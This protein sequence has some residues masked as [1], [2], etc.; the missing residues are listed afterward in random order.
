[1]FLKLG[2][3]KL[4]TVLLAFIV[5]SCG[6]SK[7]QMTVDTAGNAA[8]VKKDEV[9]IGQKYYIVSVANTVNLRSTPSKEENNVIAELA[10]G[11]LVSALSIPEASE[12]FVEVKVERT[13]GSALELAGFV[14]FKLLS[15]EGPVA[16]NKSTLKFDVEYFVVGNDVNFR[17]APSA[18]GEILKQLAK[19][20][21]IKI[22]DIGAD[23]TDFVKVEALEDSAEGF[24]SYKFLSTIPS[25]VT[26]EE[27]ASRKYFVVQNVATEVTRV[28]ERCQTPNCAH[29]MI[30]ETDIVV[31][32]ESGEETD[33]DSFLTWVGRSRISS[34]IKFYQDVEE[35][36]PSWYD[37]TSPMPPA[38]WANPKKWFKTEFFPKPAV[39]KA[40]GAFGWYAALLTP[41]VNFQWM[42]G[43]YG[44]GADEGRF[45]R[46]TRDGLVNLFADPRSSG[47]TRFEN[48]AIAYLRHILPKGT[49][50][51]RVYAFE[52]VRDKNRAAY[53]SQKA[54]G[55][56]NYI[57]TT[58]GVREEAPT[59]ERSAVLAQKLSSQEHLEEGQYKIDMF[60]DP[61]AF[62]RTLFNTGRS[63]GE[64]GDTYG[65]GKKN[66]FGYFLVDEGRFFAYRHPVVKVRR[67]GFKGEDLQA[68]NRTTNSN[69]FI[70]E[71]KDS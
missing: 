49:E 51:I 36:Y 37:P 14:S 35:H 55:V 1:M 48:G 28:Y 26:P 50:L 18:E 45:I 2:Y 40:R 41:N 60:P 30:L 4:T 16:K 10:N 43:T 23:D 52:A 8:V 46:L 11:D 33:V 58:E 12:E 68:A 31:G 38:A 17:R 22:L 67:G 15:L 62:K 63:Y 27:E 57:L 21:K 6:V 39:N 29:K 7:D 34:W 47:C 19:N 56:F 59:I 70:P 71:P 5:A 64:S 24:V 61:K 25:I 42:H 65:I 20:S 13:E 66:I 54:G 69:F 9:T 53:Q 44:W 32:R 3:A